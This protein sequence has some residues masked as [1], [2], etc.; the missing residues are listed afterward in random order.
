MKSKEAQKVHTEVVTVPLAN[1]RAKTW[2]NHLPA[3]LG[4]S[5]VGK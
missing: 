4:W 2:N 5:S 3:Q 1:E